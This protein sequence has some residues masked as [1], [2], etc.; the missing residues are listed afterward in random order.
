MDQFMILRNKQRANTRGFETTRM[1]VPHRESI[2]TN[3][4]FYSTHFDKIFSP[5]TNNTSMDENTTGL[6]SKGQKRRFP[7]IE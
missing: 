2:V 1:E 3:S 4:D 6:L 5:G 7:T